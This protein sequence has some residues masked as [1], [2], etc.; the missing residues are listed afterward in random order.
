MEECLDSASVPPKGRE[1]HP[2][3]LQNFAEATDTVTMSGTY[4]FEQFAL[5]AEAGILFRGGEPTLLGR[6]AVA[7]LHLLLEHAPAPV[8]KDALIEAA[9]PKLVVEESNLTVQIAALR[10]VLAQD[11]G[12]GWIETLPRHGYRYVGPPATRAQHGAGYT[13]QWSAGQMLEKPSIA[14]LPFENTA[15]AEWF[16]DGV[17]DDIITGLSRIK[18]L[19]VI[20]R[21][22][23]FIYRDRSIDVKQVRRD[24]GVRYVLEGSVRRSEDHVRIHAQLVDA[25]SGVHV[26][27]DRY[28]RKL[29]DVFALQDE[30]ALAVV[31]AI[32]PSL[33]RAEVER[34]RRKRPDSLDAY[35]LVLRAQ[36]DVDSG[37]PD[38]A[39][40]A[41]PLLHRAMALDPTY[42][43]AYALAAMCYHNRFLRAG[44]QEAD[45]AASIHHAR[46]ALEHGR[47]DALSLTFAGF[48]LG[49]DAHDRAAAF[50]ALEAA[51]SLSLSTAL[52][53]IFGSVLYSWAAVADRSIE[54][55]ERALRLSPFDSWAFAAFGSQALGHFLQDELPAA[56]KA[57]YL[58]VQSNPGHSINYV[59]LIGPL[60]GLNRLDEARTAAARVLELHPTF[61]FERQFSGVDC[62]P[63]LAS[64]LG[65]ALN[66]AGLPA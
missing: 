57:A 19:F 32:E 58:A 63:A 16:A 62:A 24:L 7:L 27:A 60:V 48:S 1:S 20:A 15:D 10:R 23:S 36:P 6:R 46:L 35:E 17:V 44:L 42:A 49:M 11:N 18:W 54:W 65:H 53:H 30:I 37:M 59:I 28:D 41:L 52:A 9:W 43:L 5:D 50:A 56:A 34:I 66:L 61:R 13:A 47:D 2:N 12:A 40:N 39:A 8:S 29:G 26:W 55:G 51:L 4:K 25:E 64:K 33:R 14:V 3:L 21:S 22:S 38:R 45:R 31:G